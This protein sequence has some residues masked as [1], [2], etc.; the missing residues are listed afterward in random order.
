MY[1]FTMDRS[2]AGPER[3]LSGY[4]GYLQA[5]AYS[6]YDEFFNPKKQRGLTEVGCLA[7]ARRHVLAALPTETRLQSV[8]HWIA[9]LYQVEKYAR[10]CGVVGGDALGAL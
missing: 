10:E 9:K 6:V 5:D 1:D 8:L 7:H 4:R 2:R 3:F